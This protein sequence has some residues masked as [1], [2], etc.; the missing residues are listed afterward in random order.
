MRLFW[1]G[2]GIPFSISLLFPLVIKFSLPSWTKPTRWIQNNPPFSIYMLSAFPI[3]VGVFSVTFAS[4]NKVFDVNTY[5]EAWLFWAAI[6]ALLV[7]SAFATMIVVHDFVSRPIGPYVLRGQTAD[8][9]FRLEMELREAWTKSAELDTRCSHYQKLV[10]F[11]CL[12]NV[13]KDGNIVALVY[14]VIAWGGTLFYVFYFWYVAVLVLSNQSIPPKT[15]SSLLLVFMLLITWLPMRVHT[16]WYQN[17]FHHKNWLRK[18]YAF[19]LG[20]FMAIA[21]LFFVVFIA[22][23]EALVVYCTGA[24]AAVFTFVG[25]T[26]TFKPEWLRA[27]AEFLQSTPFTYF[28][29]AYTVFLF[30]TAIIGLRVLHS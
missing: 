16:D 9:A 23:P 14:L 7:L 2:F 21:S 4:F 5:G 17:H 18:S 15:V 20:I 12:R 22:K 13:F 27:V 11:N 29:A 25:L 24:N 3:A 30:V 8:E 19:W 6:A 10:Q 26:G 28:A 1:I